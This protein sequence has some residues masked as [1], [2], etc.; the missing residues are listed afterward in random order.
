M[1][2]WT[3]TLIILIVVLLGIGIYITYKTNDDGATGGI[4]AIIVLGVFIILSF[5]YGIDSVASATKENIKYDYRNKEYIYSMEDNMTAHGS[6]GG[7]FIIGYGNVNSDIY[8]YTLV[9]NDTEGY[10]VKKYDAGKTYIV[11]DEN[12]KPY[13]VEKYIIYDSVPKDNWFFGGLVKQ[14]KTK[15]IEQVEKKELHLSKNYIKQ[16]YNIDLK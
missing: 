3:V 2:S 13:Y 16:N 12:D 10:L 15:H 6:Y 11:T 5:M 14:Y 8:Y 9:G 1:F 4:L 7:N